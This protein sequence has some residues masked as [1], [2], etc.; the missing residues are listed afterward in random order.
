MTG[1]PA[2][3]PDGAEQAAA[4]L[5]ALFEQDQVAW[6]LHDTDLRVVRS[7]PAFDALR[8]EGVTGDDWFLSMPAAA[9]R[10]ET[11]GDRLRHALHSDGPVIDAQHLLGPDGELLL[12]V[13]CYPLHDAGGAPVGVA[14]TAIDIT[15]RRRTQRRLDVLF[16][17]AVGMGGSLDPVRN[18]RELVDP[19]VPA[20]GDL[21]CVD[22]SEA[23]LR[24]RAPRPGYLD[25]ER[26]LLRRVAVKSVDGSWPEPLVQVGEA[27]PPIP[28]RPEFAT[29]HVGGMSIVSDAE[30]VRQLLGDDPLLVDKLLPEG[31]RFSMGCPL[32]HHGTVFGYVLV[33]RTHNPTPFGE[34]DVEI[35]EE[36]C[37]RTTL[38]VENAL[39]YTREH[40][41]AVVLQR[42]LLPPA[43]TE[44][45]A[46][47]TAG[48]YLPAGGDSSVGGDWF[49]AFALSSLRVALVVGDV[50][51]HG[52]QATATMARL[53]TAVQTLA[54]LDLSPDEL[55]A[56]LDDLV[57]RISEEAADSDTVGASCLFAVYDPVTRGCQL[58]SAGHP[59]PAAVLPDGTASLLDVRPGPTLG[60]GDHPF[61]LCTVQLPPG[62]VLALYSNSLVR[63]DM[64]PDAGTAPFLDDLAGLCRSGRPL[65]EI[66]AEVVSRRRP[67]ELQQDDVTLLLAR[68]RVV[69]PADTAY[70]EFEADPAA[71]AE[72]RAA[73]NA[74]LGEWQL[75]E[76]QFATELVVSELVTNA[77]RYGGGPIS[78]RLI[79][80]RVLVCEVSDPSSTQPRLRRAHGTDEGGR[81]LFLVAQLTARWGSRYGRR[82][83]TIW[84]E[85]PL[86]PA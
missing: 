31:M 34:E 8:P 1:G 41:T 43:A 10:R 56:Q 58:A 52:L 49:D 37:R 14:V 4:L 15:E 73:A 55:L 50:I 7:G 74:V 3:P 33:W 36:L 24:G 77:V 70:W 46:A 72:A 9:G 35:L 11:V 5:R 62:S 71:V 84:T 61:E 53:R 86:T 26:N 85:Q 59:A 76:L 54:A 28:D 2:L 75:E 80:D 27:M 17:G 29:T 23:V 39:R 68:T 12:S 40:S 19:L 47:E 30:R 21:A 22:V 32:Y 42:S 48:T 44:S 45:S 81:G 65:A 16:R 60:V 79:R 18:A 67:A 64:D 78:V 83:K 82:G 57:Q 25:P 38:A 6:S 69:D 63:R 51:G 66:G 20:L 13:S